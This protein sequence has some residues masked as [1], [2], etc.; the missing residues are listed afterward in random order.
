MELRLKYTEMV[1]VEDER[2]RA[3]FTSE[4][5]GACDERVNSLR[6]HIGVGQ[7]AAT[8][9]IIGLGNER[10]SAVVELGTCLLHGLRYHR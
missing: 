10:E 9:Y 1:H 2:L 7:A 8:Y 3:I 4:L 5:V 6:V